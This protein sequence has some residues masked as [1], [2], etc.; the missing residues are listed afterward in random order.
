MKIKGR[1]GSTSVAKEVCIIPRYDDEPLCLTVAAIPMTWNQ[2]SLELLPAPT[3]P[4]KLLTKP[5][6][7]KLIYTEDRKPVQYDDFNDDGY[8]K[9]D[10]KY[11][12]RLNAWMVYEALRFDESVEFENQKPA[13]LSTQNIGPWLDK[14]V[15]EMSDFGLT[16]GDMGLII[17]SLTKLSNLTLQ[18]VEK[19]RDS[20]LF[21]SRGSKETPGSFP[22]KLEEQS[23]TQ[24]SESVK[25]S[26]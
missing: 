3:P 14:I 21:Q 9:A 20:F 17:E 16:T 12:Q 22:E 10:S 6:S 19:A 15:G 7:T 5:N 24:S 18:E 2:L 8:K 1:K 4:K 25:D 23:D 11:N 26:E 13:A